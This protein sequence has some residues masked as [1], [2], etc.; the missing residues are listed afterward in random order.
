MNEFTK[1]IVFV[2]VG[3]LLVAT[4]FGVNAL[5]QPEENEEFAL[6]GEEFFP[7][8]DSP[9]AAK[10]LEIAA[11]DF[12]KREPVD[13][14]VEY[15]DKMWRIPSHHDYPAEA[16][17]RI[18]KTA[19]SIMG[20][21]REAIGGRRETEHKRFGVIDP[22]S[23][24]AKKISKSEKDAVGVRVIIGKENGDVLADYIIGK[25]VE[26]RD[27]EDDF[28]REIRGEKEQKPLHYVR[29]PDEKETYIASIEVDASTKFS[30]WIEPDLLLLDASHLRQLVINDYSFK[31]KVEKVEVL[32]GVFQ[33]IA[34]S[35]K[36]DGEEY[37]LTKDGDFGSWKLEGMDEESE[38]L[39][40]AKIS[41]L[42]R[43][44][45]NLKIQGVRPRL[46]IDGESILTPD[47]K[48]QFPESIRSQRAA[49]QAVQQVAM[50][51][52]SKGFI[53]SQD[54][55]D[56]SLSIASDKGE[57][58]AA[59]NEGAVYRLYFGK[60]FSGTE[61]EIEIGSASPQDDEK[62]D[63]KNSSN[64]KDA[65]DS[66]EATK[67]SGAEGDAKSESNSSEDETSEETSDA[68]DSD[69]EKSRFLLVRVE[70]DGQF[71]GEKPTPPVEPK[72]PEKPEKNAAKSPEKEDGDKD[73]QPEP[74]APPE[75]SATKPQPPKPDGKEKPESDAP[76]KSEDA[77][78]E[79]GAAA[80][81]E[82]EDAKPESEGGSDSKAESDS[83]GESESETDKQPSEEKPK[84]DQGAKKDAADADEKGTDD[85]KDADA[86]KD[87]GDDKKDPPA[88]NKND[89]DDDSKKGDAKDE[90]EK[91]DDP[92]AKYQE[93]LQAYQLAKIQYDEDKAKYEKDLKDYE[94]K[95]ADGKDKVVK[96]NE[97][98]ADWYYVIS[99]E[100][101]ENLRLSRSDLVKK[102][103][104]PEDKDKTGDK[105]NADKP[106]DDAAAANQKAADEFLAENKKKEGIVTT[107]S[108]LQYKVLKKGEGESPKA[109]SR[110]K[111]KY[112]GTLIDGTVFDQSGD[113]TIEFQVDGVIKGWTEA[114]QLMKPGAT[115][116]L[117]IPPKL[118]YGERGSPPKIGPNSLLIFEVELVSFE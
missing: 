77:S 8:F 92:E 41:E 99:A 43:S 74:P 50:D 76:D 80:S 69:Q 94:K 24:E 112:K 20:I 75:D 37:K 19:A 4:A 6:V 104:K 100:S 32:P 62:K 12:E 98:F 103:E 52:E 113:E 107:D 67:E 28:L 89:K 57:L 60:V 79:N 114:L 10:F 66:N 105:N 27:M 56:G 117:F 18:A 46:K 35:E 16:A 53:L 29:R 58:S 30:D 106:A 115:W 87:S 14:R 91:K 97:R 101:L 116:R 111:V 109:T 78:K 84:D 47:L 118:A 22:K 42:T 13:F 95:L 61:S 38:E 2:V 7:D 96:L 102:K 33:Q 45:D 110:V 36:V 82:S 83:K 108:G 1:T 63:S 31:T 15:K 23:K 73:D 81:R 48:I 55:N 26:T 11:F 85:D 44:L 64:G 86:N 68:K 90:S 39:Q 9:S 5:T 59:T 65:Q 3:A 70:F 54:P 71:L 40:T 72:E 34:R 21:R 25:K 17:D 51:L 93:A 88:E 49:Q